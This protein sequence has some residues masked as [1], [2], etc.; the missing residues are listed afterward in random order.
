ML[1]QTE[2]SLENKELLW[3]TNPESRLMEVRT[4]T[5]FGPRLLLIDTCEL[6]QHYYLL[7]SQK[8]PKLILNERESYMVS[9]DL[10]ARHL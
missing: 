8:H 1:V 9:I 3:P 4:E 2:I 5:N 10:R 6:Q 7:S